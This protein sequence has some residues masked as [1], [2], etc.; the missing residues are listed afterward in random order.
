NGAG[1]T[2]LLRILLG[3]LR[4]SGGTAKVD[5]LDCYEHSVAVRRRISYLPADARL[6]T[7]M[8]AIDV[9]D[10]FAHVR[11]EGDLRRAKEIAERLELDLKAWVAFMSTGM[12]QKLAIAASLSCNAPLLILDEPTSNLDP[13]VRSTVNQLVREAQARGQTIVFS[14]HVL[15]EVEEVSDRVAIMR[16]GEIVHTQKISELRQFHRIRA[17][18]SDPLP[19]P[20]EQLRDGLAIRYGADQ[21]VV[22]ETPMELSALFGWLSEQSLQ[23]VYIEPYG[24]RAVYDRFHATL[25]TP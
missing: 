11:A 3:F 16:A 7:Y 18:V 5:N 10:F 25:E 12:R 15:P 23:Q 22:I 21:Q 20:P 24:L 2:T 6:F 17:V 13:N 19:Q 4:P 8:R 9:L 14:S 1:K